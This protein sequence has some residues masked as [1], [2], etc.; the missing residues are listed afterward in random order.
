MKTHVARAIRSSTPSRS[1]L[2]GYELEGCGARLRRD[3]RG[4]DRRVAVAVLGVVRGV[5]VIV[6]FLG[7]AQADVFLDAAGADARLVAG[8]GAAEPG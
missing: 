5:N 2:T 4:N 1:L 7:F 6:R 3:D 8:L